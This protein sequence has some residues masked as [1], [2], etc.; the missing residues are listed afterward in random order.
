MSG[1][2]ETDGKI[3]VTRASLP[4]YSNTYEAKGAAAAAIG[5]LDVVDSAV[6]GQYVA[7]V[8]QT[9]GVITV[10]RADLPAMEWG[11]F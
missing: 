4:D 1:V 7:A 3:T 11:I 9:D 10:T 2:S 8:S 5:E 6:A